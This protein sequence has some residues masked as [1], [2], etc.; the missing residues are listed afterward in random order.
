MQLD[1]EELKE[2]VPPPLRMVKESGGSGGILVL[3]IG[4]AFLFFALFH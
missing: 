2:P 1:K 4:I 3:V